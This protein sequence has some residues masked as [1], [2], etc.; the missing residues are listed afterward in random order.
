MSLGSSEFQI[1]SPVLAGK[2]KAIGPSGAYGQ[3]QW[4]GIEMPLRLDKI[5]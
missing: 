1:G 2:D 3:G 5:G 4:L